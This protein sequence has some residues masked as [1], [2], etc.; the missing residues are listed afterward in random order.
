VIDR[1]RPQCG[2]PLKAHRALASVNP[3]T[4]ITTNCDDHLEFLRR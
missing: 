4:V 3:H 1:I 2:A